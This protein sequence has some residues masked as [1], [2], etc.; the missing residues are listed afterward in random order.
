MKIDYIKLNNFLSFGKDV[1]VDFT[2]TK[3][4]VLVKGVTTSE[5]NSNGAGKSSLFESVYWA[6]T[7]KTVRGVKA[8]EVMRYG[9]KSCSVQVG[10]TFA[11]NTLDIKR[12]YSN[13]KKIVNIIYNEKEESFHDSKQATGKIFDLLNTTP[14]ILA[15]SC[16]YGKNFSTF[17]RMKSSERA[18]LIDL[19]ARGDKWEKARM[20]SLKKSKKLNSD[21][22]RIDYQIESIDL[23]SIESDISTSLQ[24]IK[25]FKESN[26]QELREI[27][28]EHVIYTNKKIKFQNE[29]NN[30]P[31]V[32]KEKELLHKYQLKQQ[33]SVNKIDAMNSALNDQ[34]REF[35]FNCKNKK[36]DISVEEGKL[37]LTNHKISA[38][39]KSIEN[40]LNLQ[41]AEF[42]FKF[43]TK[44]QDILTK[45]NRLEEIKQ[46]ISV[47][48]KQKDVEV[49]RVCK[50]N[51]PHDFSEVELLKNAQE[52]YAKL[53]SSIEEM[54][55]ESDAFYTEESKKLD[56]KENQKDFSNDPKIILFNKSLKE[57]RVLIEN[58][59]KEYDTFYEDGTDKLAS[60]EKQNKDY[61]KKIKIKQ[62]ST[63][64]SISKID[65]IIDDIEDQKNDLLEKIS[66]CDRSNAKLDATSDII[67]KEKN[68]LQ[69]KAHT[70]SLLEKLQVEKNKRAD[71]GK[72]KISIVN[73]LYIAKYWVTGF[74]DIRFSLFNSTLKIMEELLNTFCSRQGLKFDKVVVTGRKEQSTGKEV[75][76]VNVTVYRDGEKYNIN[77]LSE[78]ETQRFDLA[79]FLTISTIIEKHL[80]YP[81]DFKVLDEPLVGIDFEG[82]QNIFDIINDI[83]EHKQVFVIDHDANFQDKFTTV[84][85]VR[86]NKTS[87][88]IL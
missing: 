75:P 41:R 60:T 55:K 84:L 29:L 30:L 6:L 20:E 10:F 68:V 13:S 73:D 39:K 27:K 49:C 15:L 23:D 52:S 26:K 34:K 87:E 65:E 53:E 72:K 8:S 77:S 32:E 85:T 14:D 57:S 76:D 38:H 47:Y 4:P 31:S 81:V 64:E 88:I 86:K 50:Q 17:S 1:V 63:N 28:Q 48:E 25:E 2:E 67:K 59:N 7:G 37:D 54:K 58:L 44:K 71:L 78:G 70:D 16:F 24:T 22:E 42:E 9:E 5:I 21:I 79:C 36:S 18:N 69:E 43:K 82:R 56:D 33:D 62:D 35:M 3:Y 46:E 83:S 74:K 40:K 19:V 61:I 12:T 66:N 11:G 80:G 51:L 45:E